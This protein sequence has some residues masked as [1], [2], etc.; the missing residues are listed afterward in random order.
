MHPRA[1]QDAPEAPPGI[2]KM[3]RESPFGAEPQLV[4]VLGEL[5]G[6]TEHQFGAFGPLFYP[7][8]GI[9]KAKRKD[10]NETYETERKT[11]TQSETITP[12]QKKRND[13]NET[14]ETER[15]KRHKPNGAK[16]NGTDYNFSPG[17]AAR[18]RTASTH[19]QK[20]G[21]WR[22]PACWRW[23]PR[24]WWRRTPAWLSQSMAARAPSSVVAVAPPSG[25]AKETKRAKRTKRNGTK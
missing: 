10:R 7:F 13:R 23:P 9:F 20:R 15:Q 21:R 11:Q 1:P 22:N 19:D 5:L 25:A 2:P 24:A 8:L 4:D 18:Q 12:Q 3:P 17:T 16:P 6:A 14:N